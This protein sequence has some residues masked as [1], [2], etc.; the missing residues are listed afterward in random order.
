M[1]CGVQLLI[2]VWEWMSNFNP[3]LTVHEI[4]VP[5]LK[6][7]FV[8]KMTLSVMLVNL[9]NVVWRC[10]SSTWRFNNF[11]RASRRIKSPEI[12]R[13]AQQLVQANSN[14]NVTAL[15]AGLV[16][17]IPWW[18]VDFPHKGLVRQ[19]M[20]RCHAMIMVYRRITPSHYIRIPCYWHSHLMP[21]GL[22]CGASPDTSYRALVHTIA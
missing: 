10:H 8:N 18:A 2:Q 11:I 21:V 14:G 1:K 6:K 9:Q 22:I 12:R 19:R 3:H 20:F 4:T 7:V 16:R 15:I 13:F 17:E 5:G